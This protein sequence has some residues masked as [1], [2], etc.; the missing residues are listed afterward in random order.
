MV[1][2]RGNEG[3]AV[4]KTNAERQAGYRLRQKELGEKK[5]LNIW[6]SP[7][8]HKQLGKLVKQK[9]MSQQ[10][11]IEWILTHESLWKEEID[12]VPREIATV[13]DTALPRNKLS[14]GIGSRRASKSRT[15]KLLGNIQLTAGESDRQSDLITEKLELPSQFELQL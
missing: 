13:K 10:M 7:A 14:N 9:G 6:L 4:I 15:D 8:A 3:V 11:L 1:P 12:Q 5:R 2:L